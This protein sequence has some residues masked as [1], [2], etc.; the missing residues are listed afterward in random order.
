MDFRSRALYY[1]VDGGADAPAG[2]ADQL[3]GLGLKAAHF[4]DYDKNPGAC[5]WVDTAE[6]ELFRIAQAFLDTSQTRIPIDTLA[7][8]AEKISNPELKEYALAT[9]RGLRTQTGDGSDIPMIFENIMGLY[10]KSLLRD[11]FFNVK[12]NV[13]KADTD[14]R[15]AEKI[16]IDYLERLQETRR[17]SS[18]DVYT[19]GG[20][21]GAH[22]IDYLEREVAQDAGLGIPTGLPPFDQVTGGIR[23]GEVTIVFGGTK[24]GKTSL[25][26]V[27]AAN[28][29]MFGY[30]VACAGKE[31][32]GSA[33]RRRMEAGLLSAELVNGVM[34]RKSSGIEGGLVRALERGELPEDYKQKFLELQQYFDREEANGH[35]LWVYEPNSYANLKELATL[36][37]Y[38][39]RRYGLDML[40]LDSLNIQTLGGRADD[41]HDL[42]QGSLVLALRDIAINNHIA[43]LCDAQERPQTW[44]KRNAGLE[45][46]P[47]YSGQLAQRADH[48]LRTWMPPGRENLREI[49]HHA[50]RNGPLVDPFFMFFWSQDMAFDMAPKGVYDDTPGER[51]WTGQPPDDDTL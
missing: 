32:Y 36:I 4:R 51:M 2:S 45:E 5:C 48:V 23:P 40:W 6:F 37:G 44:E 18:E 28:S 43:I 47:M 19:F 34:K 26:G 24:R 35:R 42:Q 25:C 14:P 21:S 1:L 10:E 11:T 49:Q 41:R 33:I 39:K 22:V 12:D 29:Y 38:T 27:A 17:G 8:R 16:L 9:V 46:F 7:V 20:T 30:N 13:I 3:L 15:K 50:C 31:M